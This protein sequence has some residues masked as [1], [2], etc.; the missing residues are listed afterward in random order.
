[1]STEYIIENHKTKTYIYATKSFG[2]VGGVV[3]SDLT[4]SIDEIAKKIIQ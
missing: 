3:F 1:M 2:G 4:G